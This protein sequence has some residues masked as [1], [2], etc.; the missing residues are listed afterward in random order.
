MTST[1][2]LLQAQ[3]LSIS[4]ENCYSGLVGF[5]LQSFAD[6][7]EALCTKVSRARPTEAGDQWKGLIRTHIFCFHHSVS[8]CRVI[9]SISLFSQPAFSLSLLYSAFL[10]F[11]PGC[12][13]VLMLRA[14]PSLIPPQDDLSSINFLCIP[15]GFTIYK[16]SHNVM[17]QKINAFS[18]K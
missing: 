16:E 18:S 5:D 7:M 15:S 4:G 11:L 2:K 14:G 17:V 10:F 3:G 9:L 13:E 12:P 1:V 6:L 8:F